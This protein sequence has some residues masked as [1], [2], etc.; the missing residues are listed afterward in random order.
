MSRTCFARRVVWLL[1]AFL[2][3]PICLG[4]ANSP[5]MSARDVDSNCALSQLPAIDRASISWTGG[6]ITGQA[7]G[8][9]DVYAFSDG[10]LQYI[11]RGTFEAGRLARSEQIRNCASDSCADDVPPKLLRRHQDLAKLASDKPQAATP[12][13]PPIVP[14]SSSTPNQNVQSEVH[15][16]DG[17]YRGKV[18][19]DAKTGAISGDV[20][21]EY[22][23]GRRFDGTL[24]D[25]VKIGI[26]THV[27]ADGQKYVG[28]WRNDIQHGKGAFTFANGDVY[29]GDFVEGQRTGQGSLKQKS[30]SSY[31][32]QW[33]RG[34]RDGQG[35]EEWVNGQRYE[36]NWRNNRKDGQ[37]S[38]R[39]ADGGTYDGQWRDDVADGQGD[40][41]FP[42]GDTYTGQ[43]SNGV[44]QG[45]GLFIWGSGDRFEGEF[46][47]GKPTSRGTMTFLAESAAASLSSSEPTP[48]PAPTPPQPSATGA[49]EP[50]SR[51]T[52]CATSFNAA[53]TIAAVR[54]FLDSF[55][56][57]ECGR[58]ALA[59]Q[60]IAAWE[61]QARA[62]S[63]ALEERQATAKAF[64]GAPV[65]FKQEFPFCVVGA[66]NSAS[67]QR[68]TY[69]F[70]VRAKV[71]DIDLQRRVVS[72]QITDATSLGND[73]GAP[74]ALFNE[75]RAAAT[76]AYKTRNVGATVSKTLA[77]V[78]LVF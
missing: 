64:I 23:D 68:V 35:V 41:I 62:A 55:P 71:R 4:Q 57:D 65:A 26:G 19:V 25:G 15:A 40:I 1:S 66:A 53:R 32:G 43:V 60:K 30:G 73:K 39:F 78:G 49:T 67:C 33:L 21:V 54:R 31:V 58:H 45:K 72:V 47:G 5:Q 75:G 29:E 44:P 76:S 2:A 12:V 56:D 16:A 11:L 50:P 22:L 36:G 18:I 38:M 77:E 61:E 14:A 59:R 70:D 13:A 51:A 28:E 74:A 27:W 69:V 9:G 24:K 37:G 20:N 10:K 34:A 52:L 7:S 6:C 46:E 3:T 8:V 42:S 17:V 48:G 63:R